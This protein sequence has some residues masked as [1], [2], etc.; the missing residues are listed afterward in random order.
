MQVYICTGRQK[1]TWCGAG[2]GAKK[3][4]G[5]RNGIIC[6]VFQR[7]KDERIEL[8]RCHR[9]RRRGAEFSL[10]GTTKVRV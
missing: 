8:R 10:G 4:E 5:W 6:G 2:A 1:A 7:L 3:G 9:R